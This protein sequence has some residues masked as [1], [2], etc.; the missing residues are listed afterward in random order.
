MLKQL[1]GGNREEG[2]FLRRQL[3]VDIE[4]SESASSTRPDSGAE[5]DVRT[6]AS[7]GGAAAAVDANKEK[8]DEGWC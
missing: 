8:Q 2:D 1:R 7:D 3:L 4:A 6:K 5:A